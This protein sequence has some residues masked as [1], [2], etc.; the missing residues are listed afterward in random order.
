MMGIDAS[1]RSIEI[2]KSIEKEEPMNIKYY[3]GSIC[4]LSMFDDCTFDVVISNI[5]LNDLQDIDKAI[6]ELHRVLKPEGKLVFS[7][8]HPCFSSPP[9]RGWVRKPVDSDRKE[10]W[11]YWRVDLYFDRNIEE[12]RYFDFPPFYSFHR[13]LSDYM[14][15]LIKNEFILTDFEEPV[16][17]EKDIEEHYRELGNE[18]DRIPWF[19][20]IGALKQGRKE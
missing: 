16:P 18:C 7:I 1:R 11:L 19:L 4:N 2:A 9:V 20:V 3:V 14:K 13:P 8:M 17:T 15:V 5:V 6:K 12:W 10:D